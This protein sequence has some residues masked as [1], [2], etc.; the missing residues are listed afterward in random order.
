MSEILKSSYVLPAYSSYLDPSYVP[1]Y[2]PSY[3]EPYTY[4]IPSTFS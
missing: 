2:V 3:I 4:E 1:T